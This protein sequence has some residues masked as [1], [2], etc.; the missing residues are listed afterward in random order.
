MPDPVLTAATVAQAAIDRGVP[1]LVVGMVQ[2]GTSTFVE[3]YGT[4][5]RDA[6]VRVGS[7][8][9]LFTAIAVAQLVESERIG[10]D[11]PVVRHLRSYGFKRAR[12]AP[13]ATIRQV[14]THTGGFGEFR[15]LREWRWK[16]IPFAVDD[17]SPIPPM[18]EFYADGLRGS[19]APGRGYAYA[20]HAFASLGQMVEDVTGEPYAEYVRS[21]ILR[22]LGMTSS[23]IDF[24][25]EI[26]A[27]LAQGY[28]VTKDGPVEVPLQH[29]TIAPAGALYSTVD[30]MLRFAAWVSTTGASCAG[31]LAPS[32]LAHMFER[33]FEPDL[34]LPGQGLGFAR[35]DV[36]GEAV[37]A[38]DGG[39]PGFVASF[40][41]VPGRRFGVFACSTAI[42]LAPRAVVDRSVE[43]LV[44]VAEPSVRA[45]T[46]LPLPAGYR[47]FAGVYAPTLGLSADAR[48]WMEYGG[49]FRVSADDEGLLLSSP[50]GP[51]AE[52]TRLLP[53]D[54]ADPNFWVGLGKRLGSEQMIRI[55]FDGRG[56]DGGIPQTAR[57]RKRSAMRS[58][59]FYKPAAKAAAVLGPAGA[60][61]ATAAL[62]RR[63]VRARSGRTARRS[64]RR[65]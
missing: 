63:R 65:R 46:N 62:L 59:R 19:T 41:A 40:A 1:G 60:L 29:I 49:E 17:G 10:W 9:K 54:A 45:K 21:H 51:H 42:D 11:D 13:D 5:D 6:V 48:W 25:D 61:S 22:P 15:R 12:G 55:R 34:R 36:G 3:A 53:G 31:V 32:T 56:F 52:G 43:A 58:V 50:R 57:M 7:I 4:V 38:H 30:D 14:L 37:V 18:R 39:F 28:H 24:T 44:G 35:D 2:D 64:L 8:T 16:T 26:R 27:R 33:H 47:R 20:N 23:D